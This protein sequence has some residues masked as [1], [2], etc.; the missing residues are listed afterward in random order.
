MG[1]A[2]HRRRDVFHWA[3]HKRYIVNLTPAE[4]AGLTDIV[5]RGRVSGL[6]R[7]RASILLKADEGLTDQ[8]I[9]EALDVGVVTVERVRK[10]CCERGVQTCLERKAQE[11]PSRPRKLD[12][13][14]EAQLV[15]IACSP[16]PAGRARWTVTLLADKLVELKVFDSVSAS[17]VQRG[18]KKTRSNRGW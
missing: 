12:G 7:Q 14:S 4:L 5:R 1:F 17:T 15:R 18:L 13:A 16:P 2:F 6:K 10:R 8:E 3:M 9:A 11:F